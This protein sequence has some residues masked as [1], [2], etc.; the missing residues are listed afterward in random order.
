VT[1]TPAARAALIAKAKRAATPVASCVAA[2]IGVGHILGTMTRAEVD[3]LVI[4]L[5]DAVDH[6]LLRAVVQ[7]ENDGRPGLSDLDARYRAGH[8]EAVRLRAAKL[9]VPVAVRTLDSGY[10]RGRKQARQELAATETTTT[11]ET[12]A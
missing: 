12:A 1:L 9:P 2:R 11:G 3:A 10:Y 4:V 6:A 5:A 8:A 7:A